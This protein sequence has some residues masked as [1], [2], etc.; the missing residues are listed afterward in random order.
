MLMPFWGL[1][2]NCSVSSAARKLALIWTVA[3]L[4]LALSGSLRTMPLSTAVAVCSSADPAA[5]VGSTVGGS[6]TSVIASAFVV[7]LEATGAVTVK[8]TLRLAPGASLVA[9]ANRTE[10]NAV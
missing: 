6:L 10:R 1:G 3:P 9:L 7:A 5:S 8:R 2:V 4:S